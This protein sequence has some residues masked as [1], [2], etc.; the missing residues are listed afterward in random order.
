M[1][2]PWDVILPYNIA[3]NSRSTTK[4]DAVVSKIGQLCSW[5]F[6]L[7]RL[8]GTSL[9]SVNPGALRRKCRWLDN[10]GLYISRKSRPGVFPRL[11]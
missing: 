5:P 7:G 11:D 3:A 2:S 6:L 9:R 4:E 10:A 8:S 1:L